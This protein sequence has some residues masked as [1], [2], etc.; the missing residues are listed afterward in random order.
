M[1]Y[2]KVTNVLSCNSFRTV[3]DIVKL[4]GVKSLEPRTSQ[5]GL[6]VD[7]LE[8]LVLNKYVNYKINRR[9]EYGRAIAQVWIENANINTIM[10]EF[11]RGVPQNRNYSSYPLLIR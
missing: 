2:K 1:P 6:A 4:E 9:D 7:K 10:K 8:R 5:N 3:S 11:I